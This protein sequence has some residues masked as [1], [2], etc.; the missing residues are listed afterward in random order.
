MEKEVGR[1]LGQVQF[2]GVWQ[3]DQDVDIRLR[4]HARDR[5]GTDVLDVERLTVH[6]LYHGVSHLV[7]RLPVDDGRSMMMGRSDVLSR[8]FNAW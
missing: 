3:R 4:P 6:R 5:C 1:L 2:S 8:T 7:E